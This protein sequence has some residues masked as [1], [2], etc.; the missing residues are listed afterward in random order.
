[1][2]TVGITGGIGSGKSTAA[3]LFAELGVTI[4][5]AD[6]IAKDI[7]SNNAPLQQEVI[8]HFGDAVLDEHKQ[9]R[10]EKL[11]DIIF[12]DPKQ[13]I[14]LESLLHPLVVKAI[15]DRVNQ[16]ADAIDTDPDHAQV[17]YCMIAIPL[18]AEVPASW[19]L[20]NRVLVIDVDEK[21]QLT[22]TMQRD[23]LSADHI[24]AIIDAQA[25]R[26]KR[27]DIADDVIYNEGDLAALKEQVCTVHQR[28]LALA[29]MSL[30]EQAKTS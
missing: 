2:L 5:D 29:N 14:W 26:Q 25:S 17:P 19:S 13:K 20:I 16:L 3:Q 23:H 4:I 15:Q 24:Q 12:A 8:A 30:S 18:L 21:I 11:R 22:R 7:L 10:R 27:L 1:M 9:L 28:Y 6:A